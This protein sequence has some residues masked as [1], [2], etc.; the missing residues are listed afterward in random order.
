M[1]ELLNHSV[2][3]KP[4]QEEGNA[5][6]DLPFRGTVTIAGGA[7]VTWSGR[8][9]STRLSPSYRGAMIASC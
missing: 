5:V 1:V 9:V 6:S 7:S 4:S 8:V 3:D 2:C